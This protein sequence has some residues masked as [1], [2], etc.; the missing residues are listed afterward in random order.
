MKQL[1]ILLIL[2]AAL[3]SS[4]FQNVVGKEPANEKRTDALPMWPERIVHQPSGIAL[5][6]IPAGEF[7]M[8]SPTMEPDRSPVERQHRRIVRQAFYLGETE[9]T[10]EQFRKFVQETGYTTDAERGVEE[11][12]H[13]GKGA[14][15]STPQGDRQWS[16]TANWQNPF[17][18]IKQY[19]LND[20]HPVVQVTWA[21]AQRFV[22]HFGLRLPTEAQW[23]YATR[24]GS[25]TRFFWGNSEAEGKG[26]G[27]VADTSAHKRFPNWNLFFPFDDGSWLL[28][29]VGQ[30]KGNPWKLRD[31]VGN[32]SEWCQDSFTK[33]YPSDG[34][35]ESPVQG[36]N[37]SSRVIRGGSW[38]DAPAT[39]R[40]AKR[41]GFA[42]HGRRDFVGF[43]VAMNLAAEAP[44]RPR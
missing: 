6:L 21:D 5:I 15:A 35:D 28:S 23:E 42:P 1:L 31:V 12:G 33:D 8:G 36:D 10:V 32:V 22:A 29:N 44:P 13:Y 43:R 11:G 26:F 24:A 4:L 14:F 9:V 7:Q 18:N 39:Q 25:R 38:L 2:L 40:S 27:N 37:N 19:K 20:N 16:A 17:P 34:T 41:I 3:A 30:Y